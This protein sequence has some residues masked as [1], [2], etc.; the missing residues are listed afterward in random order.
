MPS[1]LLEARDERLGIHYQKFGKMV[2]DV[3]G[4]LQ[5]LPVYLE[6]SSFSADALIALMNAHEIEKAVILQ[7]PAFKNIQW[8]MAA[9]VARYPDRLRASMVIEPVKGAVDELKKRLAAG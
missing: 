8:D 5:R 6:D 1:W 2:N 4:E 7:S 9:A 3:G